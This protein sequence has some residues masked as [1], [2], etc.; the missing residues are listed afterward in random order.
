M[1]IIVSVSAQK[2]TQTQLINAVVTAPS[3]KLFKASLDSLETHMNGMTDQQQEKLKLKLNT[4]VQAAQKAG[5]LR[6]TPAM[7]A[8]LSTIMTSG[9]TDE[10]TD[11]E[12][13][14][15]AGI[16]V[17]SE[18]RT[19]TTLPAVISKEMKA[20]GYQT[21]SWTMVKHLPGYLSGAIRALGRQ[22]FKPFTS[23]PIEEIQVL[24]NF[25]GAGSSN[26]NSI[27]ELKAVAGWLEKTGER[28]TDA[29]VKLQEILPG[30]EAQ[31]RVYRASGYE[32]MV[33]KD[34]AGYYIYSYTTSDKPVKQLR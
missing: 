22:I 30:Y 2:P 14:R 23:V 26:P 19:Q 34:F 1:K 11:A 18:P 10:I 9:L 31:I 8:A 12:A 33:V 3:P 32:F 24:A 20:S 13:R 29:E 16:S 27:E 5:N 6:I 15:N 21:P 25:N 4:A 7:A 28:I 17:E